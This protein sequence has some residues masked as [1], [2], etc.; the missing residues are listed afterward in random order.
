MN[1]K[2]AHY[3]FKPPDL[4]AE[5]RTAIHVKKLPLGLFVPFGTEFP[6]K[7]HHR[8]TTDVLYPCRNFSGKFP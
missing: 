1:S 7:C 5:A 6:F 3:D 4:N 8:L 2:I